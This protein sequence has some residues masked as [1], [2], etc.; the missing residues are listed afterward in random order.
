MIPLKVT[1]VVPAWN[2]ADCLPMTLKA[3]RKQMSLS[4]QAPSVP[5]DYQLIVVDD[6]SWDGTA[7]SA[8]P[9]ADKVVRH[10]RRMGKGSA[11]ESGW[12]ESSGD[13]LIFLDADLGL[14]AKH[15]PLLLEP[16]IQGEADM[17]VASLTS[18][19]GTGGV[20]L[21]RALAAKGIRMLTGCEV[22]APLS[23]QRAI[24]AQ[25]LQALKRKYGGFGVEVGMCVDLLKLGY[26]I[27]ETEVPF[28]HRETGRS[29]SG[30]M[31]R[32]KQFLAVGRTLW[33][34]WRAPVC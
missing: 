19:P 7:E 22:K 15:F 3:L 24:R 25:A 8:L 27:H 6:G 21:V 17:V 32:G 29:W 9:W 18:S 4:K 33:H 34:C 2:E 26:R 23:G 1:I 11:L 14:S 10:P 20:G 30:W 31:H 28:L 12:R 13:V 16:V 5:V